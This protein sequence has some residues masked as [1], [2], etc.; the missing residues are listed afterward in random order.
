[1]SLLRSIFGPG[2]L[3]SYRQPDYRRT[4]RD[5]NELPRWAAEASASTFNPSF[6]PRPITESLYQPS[7]QV[8]LPRT[9]SPSADPTLLDIRRREKQLEQHLQSLLDAQAEGL[10]EGLE[11]RPGQD[12]IMSTGSSTPTL[13]TAQSTYTDGLPTGKPRRKP[14]LRSARKGIRRAIE[15]LAAVKQEEGTLLSNDLMENEAT[16]DQILGWE[17]K[18]AGLTRTIDDIQRDNTNERLDELAE[19]ARKLEDQIMDMEAR[20]AKMKTRHRQL[21]DEISG[22][23]NSVQ[24]KLSSYKASLE[25][26]DSEVKSFLRR[27][28]IPSDRKT[29]GTFLA[30]PAQRRTLDLAKDYWEKRHT[31]LERDQQRIENDQ[32]ALSEGA[33]MWDS[34]VKMITTFEVRLYEDMQGIASKPS[35]GRDRA[36]EQASRMESLMEGMDSVMS[37]LE[38]R[39]EIAEGKNWSLLVCCIGAELEAF[40]Q[41]R[42]ILQQA[43]SAGTSDRQNFEQKA[44]ANQAKTN[45]STSSSSSPELAFRPTL[46]RQDS[47]DHDGPDPELLISH[48][49]TDTD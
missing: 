31:E 16:L 41:G 8:R 46:T 35:E 19:E 40:R 32:S 13:R 23:E 25:L 3:S 42:D 27:P 15:E 33:A 29:E 30:L 38:D 49:D 2:T 6:P 7:G 39:L 20:L 34:V 44:P 43:F 22:I 45:G 37:D 4:R 14:G 47:Q 48:Q 11:G 26:L 28:P 9:F 36:S 18:R 21:V 10:I 17:R 24:S 1:M 5:S 12:D